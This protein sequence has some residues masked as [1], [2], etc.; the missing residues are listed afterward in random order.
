MKK[1]NSAVQ[2]FLN[3]KFRRPLDHHKTLTEAQILDAIRSESLFGVV[4]CDI[5]VPDRLKPN[6][7]EICPILKNTEISRDDIGEYMRAFAEEQN[8][9]AQPR[10]SL[11]GSSFGKKILLATPLIKWY[12]EHGL[13]VTH[14]Y[15]V[16]YTP[17]ACFKPFGEAVSGARRA[18]D[19]DPNKAIKLVS[20]FV[21]CTKVFC[22]FRSLFKS[23][24]HFVFYVGNSS[25]GK[26]IT[27][28]ERHR[29]VKF[30]EETK[31][32]R[33]INK[34]FFKQI[35]HISDNTYEVQSC[36]K[37][38][39]LNLPMLQFYFD[40]LDKYLDRSDFQYCEMDTDSAYIAISGPSVESLV[41]P[42]LEVQFHKDKPNWFPRTD[43]AEHKAYDKRTPGLFK[44]EWSGDGIIGLSS[45]T[46]YCFGSYDKFSCKGVN[47][48]TNDINKNKYLNV[49]LTKQSNA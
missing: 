1:S 47:K 41:K 34:P 29:E 2:H 24:F 43:T 25:Y 4:E 3:S 27:D 32:S 48:K 49:L 40:F 31:A 7:S 36:K 18:G 12:L 15:Q 16:V 30:C 11:T 44:E 13:Q 17:D 8:I 37:T 42:E 9:M 38:I 23:Y 22:I 6:F 45:K 28:Q 39:K 26:T 35:D 46:Y 14:I 20:V 10:R 33:L 19:V 21:M 5:P